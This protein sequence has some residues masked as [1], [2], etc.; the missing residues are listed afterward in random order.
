MADDNVRSLT[1]RQARK[2]ANAVIE[3]VQVLN[4]LPIMYRGVVLRGVLQGLE[5]EEGG[6]GD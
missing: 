3:I 4:E 6:S 1:D 5:E 2:L